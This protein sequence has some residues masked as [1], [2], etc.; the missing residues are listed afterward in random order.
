MFN[1]YSYKTVLLAGIQRNKTYK[2]IKIKLKKQTKKL[3]KMKF[4]QLSQ[5]F[6]FNFIYGCACIH[7]FSVF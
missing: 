4:L 7:L 3:I 6:Y 5:M 2:K 1:T